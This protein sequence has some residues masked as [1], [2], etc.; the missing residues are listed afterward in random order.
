MLWNVYVIADEECRQLNGEPYDSEQVAAA[1]ATLEDV[2][3]VNLIPAS[4]TAEDLQMRRYEH[5]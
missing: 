3:A 2:T 5:D 1:L 4:I